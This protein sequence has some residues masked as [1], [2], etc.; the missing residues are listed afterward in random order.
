MFLNEPSK[1]IVEKVIFSKGF[2]KNPFHQQ[3]SHSLCWTC[4]TV[5]AHVVCGDSTK[6]MKQWLKIIENKEIQ[7]KQ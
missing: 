2:K 1:K 6:E 5:Y 7:V 3:S 4:P